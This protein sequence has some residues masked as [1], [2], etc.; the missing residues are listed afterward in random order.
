ML[1]PW[2][3]DWYFAYPVQKGEEVYDDEEQKLVGTSRVLR[4]G[5]FGY[6]A[7]NVRSA[8]RG[9]GAPTGRDVNGGFRVARTL[10]LGSFTALHLTP[11]GSKNKN[12]LK[13]LY[14][15]REW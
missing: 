9:S 3:Q 2:C 8:F 11:Q 13:H 10:P 15:S 12:Q 4:G 6:R 7:S 1:A 14:T 5:S